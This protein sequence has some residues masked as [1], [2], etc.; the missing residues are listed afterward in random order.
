[1]LKAKARKCAGTGIAQ[2]F[3]CGRLT[4]HRQYGLCKSACYPA[5]LTTTDAGKVK[6]EKSII[7]GRRNLEREK[8]TEAKKQKRELR[9]S[10]TNY[11]PLLQTEVQKIARLIDKGLLCPVR[12]KEGQQLHGGHVHSKGAH[13]ECRFNLQNIH[14]QSAES[15]N[16]RSDER[17]FFE[18]LEKEYGSDYMAFVESL[19]NKPVPKLKDWEYR[20]IYYNAR[21]IS[22]RLEKE[23]DFPRSVQQRIELRNQINLELGIYPEEQSKAVVQ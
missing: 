4:Q 7:S 3:G 6:L 5:W 14:R 1:M 17:L 18:A 12:P 9:E 15:N 8:S 10:S 2:G 22:A 19:T 16:W 23:T 13:P 20:E 11:K 21:K